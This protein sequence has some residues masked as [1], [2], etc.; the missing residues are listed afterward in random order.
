MRLHGGV[1]SPTLTD[2]C[3]RPHTPSAA[4]AHPT[5]GR[6]PAAAVVYRQAPLSPPVLPTAYKSAADLAN[7]RRRLG[8]V[9][10]GV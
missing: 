5:G 2:R 3:H 1:S 8:G 7:G 4:I 10:G 6:R 9:Y